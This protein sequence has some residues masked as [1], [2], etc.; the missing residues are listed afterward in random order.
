L[1]FQAFGELYTGEAELF[2]AHEVAHQ[3][4][5]AGVEWRDYRD[6]WLSEGFAQYAAA[7]YVASGLGELDK[8]HDMIAAWRRDVL[9]EMSIGQ[10]TG[11]AHYGFRP[12]VIRKSQASAS[13]PLVAGF[14]LQSTRTPF[15][16]RLIVYEKGALILHMLRMML[17]DPVTGDDEPFRALMR[18]FASRHMHGV[19]ATRDFEAAVSAAFG[20]PMDWFFDQWVYGVEIPTYRPQL[21]VS[22]LVDSRAPFLLHGTITQEDVPDGFRMLVPIVLRFA[23]RPPIV[24]RVWIDRPT[25]TVELPLP[26]RPSTIAFNDGDSVLARVR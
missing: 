1:S 26:A 16:Y 2:R 8:F 12:A 10:G 25:V 5:G 21:R 7:L 23:D 4:W 20:Q 22:P 24:H 18:S 13:G 11:L 3:W 14:R 6:Q 17:R 15:D 9:G 19:V